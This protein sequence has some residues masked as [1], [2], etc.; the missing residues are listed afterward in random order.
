MGR[1][2]LRLMARIN[3]RIVIDHGLKIEGIGVVDQ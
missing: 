3:H 1:Q 2:G